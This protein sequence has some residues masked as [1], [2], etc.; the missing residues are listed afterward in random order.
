MKVNEQSHDLPQM[1]TPP[2]HQLHLN[3]DVPNVSQ[4]SHSDFEK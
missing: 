4:W 3:W 2:L 1:L